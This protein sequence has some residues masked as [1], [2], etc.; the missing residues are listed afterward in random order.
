MKTERK[1]WKEIIYHLLVFL[2]ALIMVYPLLWMVFSSTSHT[3]PKGR[4]AIAT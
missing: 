2:G 4:L 3:F 1:L